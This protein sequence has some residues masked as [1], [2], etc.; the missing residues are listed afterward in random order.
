VGISV[1]IRTF[2]S[3][4]TLQSVLERLHLEKDDELI[5]VDS[6]SSD[7][8]ISI[9]KSFGAAVIHYNRPFS[10]SA[11]LNIGFESSHNEWVLVLSSHTIPANHLFMDTLRQFVAVASADIVVG[12]G[13]SVLSTQTATDIVSGSAYERIPADE[14]SCGAGNT[15]ALYRKS[16]WQERQFNTDITT[17][18]D[19]EW[20]IWATRRGYAAAKINGLV[21]TYRNQ[22][23]LKHM[24]SKGWSEIKQAQRLMPEKQ[25]TTLC[26]LLLN[27]VTGAAYFTKLWILG[28]ISFATMCR[29]QSH[30]L[31]AFFAKMPIRNW[32]DL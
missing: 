9:A 12:Y 8:T 3:G 21:G 25:Q 23:S 2:N 1:L 22:G 18:E 4:R 17:A 24:F 30:H 26:K 20:L 27:L 5:I 16:A 11:T 19:L 15:L 28:G 29:Q 7:T 14:V 6:G 13:S 32:R 10:Y 31:G